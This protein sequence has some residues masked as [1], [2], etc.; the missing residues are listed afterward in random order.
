MM[1]TRM[2]A[3]DEFA[4]GKSGCILCDYVQVRFLVVEL[5]PAWLINQI[6]SGAVQ[7]RKRYRVES[8]CARCVSQARSR[9][10]RIIEVLY[11]NE[12]T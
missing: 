4:F 5:Q 11:T 3:E 10:E 2:T 6:G 1:M 9:G 7:R 12:M 8:Y